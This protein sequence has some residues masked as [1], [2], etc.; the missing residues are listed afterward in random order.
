MPLCYCTYNWQQNFQAGKLR[1]KQFELKGNTINN[2]DISIHRYNNI[3]VY[4]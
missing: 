2:I 1:L 4:I 3:Y